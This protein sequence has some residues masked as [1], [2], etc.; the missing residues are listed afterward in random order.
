MYQV[1]VVED[2][3]ECRRQIEEYIL[4][5][6][7]EH[8]LSFQVTT[9]EDGQ[10]IA[11][12]E[13]AVYDIIFFDIEME[14]MNGMDAAAEVRRRDADVV[15]VFITNMAQYAIAGYAVGALDFVLKPI[16]Y[17]GFSFRM[18]RAMGRMKKKET[19]E[20][21]I[22]TPHGM[23]RIDSGDIYYVEIENRILHYYTA[24]GEFTQRGTM[25]SAEEQL[26]DYHFVKCNHWYLVNVK[27]V[28]EI[29]DNIVCVADS[30]LEISRRNRT[31]FI[32]AVTEYIGGGL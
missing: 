25:Q 20:I 18:Q 29:S 2:E 15:I 21:V 12:D 24:E 30:R 6:G 9:Y 7:Q 5:Y 3:E 17:Y 22:N 19:V 4:R 13:H 32:K 28:S 14:G 27:Y 1:A 11:E 16:D 23:K 31:A 10:E 8:N 26:K